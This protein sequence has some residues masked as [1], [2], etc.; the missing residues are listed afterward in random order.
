MRRLITW[1]LVL[2]LSV[3]TKLLHMLLNMAQEQTRDATGLVCALCSKA[4]AQCEHPQHCRIQ[5]LKDREALLRDSIARTEERISELA[6][7]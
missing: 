4:E 3:K 6:S 7:A 1:P 5:R 2:V